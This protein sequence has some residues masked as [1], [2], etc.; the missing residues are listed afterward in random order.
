MPY[1]SR[2]NHHIINPRLRRVLR[3]DK[4]EPQV[5]RAHRGREIHRIILERARA[6]IAGVHRV[7]GLMVQHHAHEPF[8]LR[9]LVEIGPEPQDVG[10]ADGDGQ[11]LVHAAGPLVIVVGHGA[12]LRVFVGEVGGVP[13]RYEGV[14]GEGDVGGDPRRETAF[15]AAVADDVVRGGGRTGY[16]CG[17]WGGGGG[18]CLGGH[19]GEDGRSAG[20]SGAVTGGSGAACGG[21]AAGE[22]R[23]HGVDGG[24]VGRADGGVEGVD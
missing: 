10:L 17:G 5:E 3:N 21:C 1:S 16:G 23:G 2:H 14:L 19:G 7:H 12:D 22:A 8:G 9:A 15:E 6:E 20:A 11:I 4:L 18:G 13:R 24:D